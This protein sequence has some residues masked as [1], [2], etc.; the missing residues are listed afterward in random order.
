MAAFWSAVW[1]GSP[2]YHVCRAR[3]ASPDLPR[4]RQGLVMA[5]LDRLASQ[6]AQQ[7][8]ASP[9]GVALMPPRACTRQ[10]RLHC[11]QPHAP[12]PSD[13]IPSCPPHCRGAP[14]NRTCEP[15]RARSS[16]CIRYLPPAL[17]AGAPA[18]LQH[19]QHQQQM[20]ELRARVAQGSLMQP[21][22][23]Q[24]LLTLKHLYGLEALARSAD[25]TAVYGDAAWEVRG[26]LQVPARP[27]GG[28]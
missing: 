24:L 5:M 4:M 15:A 9:A 1:K 19:Q 25:L 23:L 6:G 11:H 27:A 7:Q 18:Q 2:Q 14:R 26:A 17:R 13:A 16:C 28:L 12:V 8:A 22:P 20:A 3:L 21:S 10:C